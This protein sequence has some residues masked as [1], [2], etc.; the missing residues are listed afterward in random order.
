MS[1]DSIHCHANWA[2]HLGG[3][4]FPLLSDFEPKGSVG[5]QYGVYLADQGIH[6]RATVLI[7][8]QGVIRWSE[9]VGPSGVR[10]I[11]ALLQRCV[12]LSR[13][14]RSPSGL[15]AGEPLPGE[16]V[17]FVKSDCGP[18]A[19]VLAA[20]E[21]LHLQEN[22]SVVNVTD[23]DEGRSRLKELTGADQ[24]PCLRLGGQIVHESKDITA[25]LAR[26]AAPLPAQLAT[27][28]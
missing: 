14:Q 6:D 18:S 11:P 26:W 5:K 27:R 17:L 10:D 19:D 28:G 4:S 2:R 24:S 15:P 9:S 16:S 25:H 1:I 13:S 12:D 22:I 8:P 3:I 23:S 7:D 20:V 21:N